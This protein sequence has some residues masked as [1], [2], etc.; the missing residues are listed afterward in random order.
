LLPDVECSICG[1]VLPVVSSVTD[2]VVS[3]DTQFSFRPHIINV[4]SKPLLELNS[5]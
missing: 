2:L 1:S 3:Y 5:S 4:V